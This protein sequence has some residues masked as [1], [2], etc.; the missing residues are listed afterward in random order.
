[1]CLNSGYLNIDQYSMNCSGKDD[2]ERQLNLAVKWVDNYVEAVRRNGLVCHR[3]AG[4]VIEGPNAE[5][6][7]Y[8]PRESHA[9]LPPAFR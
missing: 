3:D 5:R 7:P 2:R 6:L 1:M 9:H 8:N 4:I